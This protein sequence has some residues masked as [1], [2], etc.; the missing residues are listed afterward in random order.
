MDCL[1]LVISLIFS[2]GLIALL[3]LFFKLAEKDVD[4]SPLPIFATLG[5]V[6][7]FAIL[8]VLCY[9]LILFLKFLKP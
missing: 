5:T 2:G 8:S 9:N 7:I 1:V 3:K 4:D 6:A